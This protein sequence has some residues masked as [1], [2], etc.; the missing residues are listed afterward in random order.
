MLEASVVLW[1]PPAELPD[2]RRAGMVALDL[3]TKDDGLLAERGSGWPWGG[4]HICGLSIAYRADGEIR[5]HYFPLRHPDSENFE[6][7]NVTRWLTDHIAAGVRI[8]TQNGL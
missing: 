5:A 7:E 8:V 2:L 6:R 3:E 1:Q 4:G